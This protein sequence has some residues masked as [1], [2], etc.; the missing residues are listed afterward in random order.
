M[1]TPIVVVARPPQYEMVEWDGSDEAA[2]WI[3]ANFPDI[4]KVTGEGD[5]AVLTLYGSWQI[6]RGW[7]IQNRENTLQPLP[8]DQLSEWQAAA[9]GLE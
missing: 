1:A 9:P 6:D 7:F 2:A 4:A 8:P 5:Q 3:T